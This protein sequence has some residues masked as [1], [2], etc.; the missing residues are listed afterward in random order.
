MTLDVNKKLFRRNIKKRKKEKR[1]IKDIGNNYFCKDNDVS[2]Y[3][4]LN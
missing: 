1:K 3:S 4:I 2:E